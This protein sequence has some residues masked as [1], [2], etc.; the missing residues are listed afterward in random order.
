[1]CSFLS[2]QWLGICL[3]PLKGGSDEPTAHG[4]STYWSWWN[5]QKIN[6]AAHF[7]CFIFGR[8]SRPPSPRDFSEREA[9]SI[10]GN[11]GSAGSRERCIFALGRFGVNAPPLQLR[12][13]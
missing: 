11:A 9:G 1:M 2:P 12:N 3:P 10:R 7:R 8:I 5:R 6:Q 4:N 13:S